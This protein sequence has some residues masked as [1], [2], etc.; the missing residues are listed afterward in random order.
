MY[1]MHVERRL[2]VAPRERPTVVRATAALAVPPRRPLVFGV[3]RFVAFAAFA[4]V[5]ACASSDAKPPVSPIIPADSTRVVSLEVTLPRS[6]ISVGES[7]GATATGYDV[8]GG[9]T[10]PPGITWTSSAPSV[11]TV[12]AVGEV[13]GLT[14]GSTTI[15]AMMDT[16]S[17]S[18]LVLVTAPIPGA[19]VTVSPPL[20]TIPRNSSVQLTAVLR[21]SAGTVET[22]QQVGWSSAD[23][24]VATVTNAGLVTAEGE[25]TVTISATLDGYSSYAT[26][27]ATPLKSTIIAIK[28]LKPDTSTSVAD[29]VEIVATCS[30]ARPLTKVVG[31]IGARTF[32]LH[33]IR[34]GALGGGEG[35]QAWVQMADFIPGDYYAAVT[36]YDTSDATASDSV[37]FKRKLTTDGGSGTGSGGFRIIAPPPPPPKRP[38]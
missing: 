24:T 23:I 10:R 36:V 16:L 2:Q 29:S 19:Q 26:I 20:S 30:P 31:H 11:A 15:T 18:A 4:A 22:P 38:R 25:G 12:S 37:K 27:R 14:S 5:L 21:D 28:V 35:W 33:A 17:A 9:R 34:I 6:L 7:I 13:S 1:Y 3:R 8:R 32:T